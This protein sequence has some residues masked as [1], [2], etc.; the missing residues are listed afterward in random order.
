MNQLHSRDCVWCGKTISEHTLVTAKRRM[1]SGCSCPDCKYLK[2]T[3]CSLICTMDMKNFKGRVFGD[4]KLKSV[5]NPTNN[6]L[7]QLLAI[8]PYMM[9]ERRPMKPVA[10]HLTS[11]IKIK[12]EKKVV[13]YFGKIEPLMKIVKRKNVAKII[14]VIA[15]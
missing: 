8:I 13:G 12:N 4:K 9:I 6:A 11:L 5:Q 14:M 15:K 2:R 10:Q 1:I 3:T 7:K